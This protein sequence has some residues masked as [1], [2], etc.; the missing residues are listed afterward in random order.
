MTKQ[1]SPKLLRLLRQYK[2]YILLGILLAMTSIAFSLGIYYFVEETHAEKAFWH[3]FA[4]FLMTFG[5]TILGAGLIGGGIGGSINFIFE[6]L[7][8]EEEERK[9][10]LKKEEEEKKE[11]IKE[12]SEKREKY[13]SFRREMQS[14]LQHAH[15]NVELARILLKSHR[16]GKTYG[17]QIRNRIMPSLISLQD[18][19][20]ELAYVED[21][22]LRENLKYLQVSLA[23]LIAYLSVLIEEFEKN[24]LT[25]SNLQTYQDDLASKIRTFYMEIKESE[26]ES[27]KALE[28]KKQFLE[29][30]EG[31][32]G[33]TDVPAHIELVWHAIEELDYARD[34]IKELRNEKWERSKY[35]RYFL[36]HY[37]H[38]KQILKTQNNRVDEVLIAKNDFKDNLG[39]LLRIDE[40]K[41][42]ELPLTKQD[43]LIRKI[44][45]KEL[46]FD[47]ETCKMLPKTET[48]K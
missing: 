31:L 22:Q 9:E 1:N 41:E 15:D 3:K 2:N 5:E 19:R 14:K 30:A 46:R 39:E 12:A 27:S 6:E 43:S 20:R 4:D 24:Y 40:K 48:S 13:K 35:N 7:K 28:K 10:K 42:G 18:F 8:K 23:Y 47:F 16:S 29:N 45:E 25:I 38:C 36:Q 32:I 26:I 37:K 21:K 11:E 34:F 44:M 17:E 33:K